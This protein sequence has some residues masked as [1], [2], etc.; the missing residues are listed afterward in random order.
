MLT[1]SDNGTTA[2]MA[3]GVDEAAVDAKVRTLFC[4]A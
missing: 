4:G 1:N 3:A 2:D